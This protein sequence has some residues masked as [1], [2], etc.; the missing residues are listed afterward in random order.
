MRVQGLFGIP[1]GSLKRRWRHIYS[2][3]GKLL[4]SCRYG[5]SVVLALRAALR[6]INDAFLG[7]DG[8]CGL[9]ERV[10]GVRV[11]SA[12]LL[13]AVDLMDPRRQRAETV[14]VEPRHI[15]AD[16]LRV[17]R[18]EGEGGA[19]YAGGGRRKRAGSAGSVG[20]VA[21]SAPGRVWDVCAHL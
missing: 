4:K 2:D 16:E 11:V 12:E 18:G 10:D 9:V 20:E 19:C 5:L 6:G 15:L 21:A 1:D 8:L 14:E 17:D 7:R 3:R 13:L